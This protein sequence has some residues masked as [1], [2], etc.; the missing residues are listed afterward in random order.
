[1]LL[2]SS[3]FSATSIDSCVN[4]SSSGVYE[5]NANLSGNQSNGVC[6]YVNASDVVLDGKGFSIVGDFSIANVSQMNTIGI[7]SDV[8]LD[9]VTVKNVDVENYSSNFYNT[10]GI[11]NLNITD[12]SFEYA[13]Y[14]DAYITASYNLSLTSNYFNNIT[15]TGSDVVY[16]RYAKNGSKI[17]NNT[18]SNSSGDSYKLFYLYFPKY[19]LV[20]NNTFN[21]PGQGY[22]EYKGVS[23][24]ITS[25]TFNEDSSSVAMDLIGSFDIIVKENNIYNAKYAVLD[26]SART[27]ITSNYF[28]DTS[29]TGIKFYNDGGV[30]N[31]E[32]NSISGN[33]FDGVKDYNGVEVADTIYGVHV[34]N[35]T[36][37]DVGQ[38]SWAIGRAVVG[39][40][41]WIIE[42][43]SITWSAGAAY[44]YYGITGGANSIIRNNHVYGGGKRGIQEVGHNNV[45]IENNLLED[46][47]EYGV[48]IKN[49][50]ESIITG[51][52]ITNA[53]VGVGI[54]NLTNDSF[55]NN[56]ITGSA[57]GFLVNQSAFS[58]NFTGNYLSVS[59]TGIEVDYLSNNNLFSNNEINGAG[60]DVV[61]HD[62][63]GNVFKNT[64][65][66]NF[67]SSFSGTNFLLNPIPQPALSPTGFSSLQEYFNISLLSANG[68]A[69]VNT[70]Y[71]ES[72]LG[73]KGIENESSLAYLNYNSSSWT[74]LG[75]IV[76]TSADY[77]S[78]N[79]SGS[80]FSAGLF[81]KIRAAIVVSAPGMNMKAVL[82]LF[83]IATI[84]FMAINNFSFASSK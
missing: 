26:Y 57:D 16:I 13:Y 11:T 4:I 39:S 75:G 46:C 84:I 80:N 38:V 67:N 14:R 82:L 41:G 54:F 72:V 45:T 81:G 71:D 43:N 69:E 56:R 62:V 10:V 3:A 50:N 66:N 36:F 2:A 44:K 73:F 58:N 29:Y 79:F 27:N 70:S 7:F 15:S 63:S 37:K 9:N 5:L 22:V 33:V 65:L 76:N 21:S 8:A 17:L 32:N 31:A 25:N 78:Y 1:M 52:N 18:F 64:I 20:S 55:D 28:K 42:N 6:L 77:V 51:N 24:N 83:C 40:D 47:T 34:F 19:V 68:W 12:S 74:E 60:T 23:D 48:F 35:N 49:A 61:L 59:G 53:S 30:C